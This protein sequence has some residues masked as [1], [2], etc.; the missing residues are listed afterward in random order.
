ME[1]AP[2]SPPPFFS[3]AATAY[4][5]SRETPVRIGRSASA[6]ASRRILVWGGVVGSCTAP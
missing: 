1:G 5:R 3:H 6:G 2:I 4:L